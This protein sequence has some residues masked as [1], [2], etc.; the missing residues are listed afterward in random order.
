MLY[1]A[2]KVIIL[3][4]K[5]ESYFYEYRFSG[6]KDIINATSIQL[7]IMFLFACGNFATSI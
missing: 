3:N 2:I 7:L 4:S 1:A 5:N 6:N